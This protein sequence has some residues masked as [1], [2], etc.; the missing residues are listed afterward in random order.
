M[1]TSYPTRRLEVPALPPLAEALPPVTVRV[2]CLVEL[3]LLSCR[4]ILRNLPSRREES[5]SWCLD[6]SLDP[7]LLSVTPNGNWL[8]WFVM[9]KLYVEESFW[10]E[11]TVVVWSLITV[12]PIELCLPPVRI[13]WLSHLCI[14]TMVNAAKT[15]IHELSIFRESTA[16][17]VSRVSRSLCQSMQLL[18]ARVTKCSVLQ[19]LS[20]S[21]KQKVWRTTVNMDSSF[22]KPD[23]PCDIFS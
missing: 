7:S 13:P 18:T 8:L 1:D 20:Y 2:L 12:K 11:L 6:S 4:G 21:K 19:V 3:L 15:K 10:F 23:E 22:L 17:Q 16:K 14:S 5:L 9:S